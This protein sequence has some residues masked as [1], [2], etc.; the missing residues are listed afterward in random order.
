MNSY[1]YVQCGLDNV[2]LVNGFKIENTPYGAGVTI[3][4]PDALNLAIAE[5]LTEK[6]GRLSGQ[7]FRFLR[8]ELD[9]SQKR[10]GELLGREA[11]TIALWEKLPELNADAD[12]L[13]RHIYRQTKINKR[14]TYVEMVD[15][16]N[17]QDRSEHEATLNFEETEKGWKRIKAA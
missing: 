4:D 12:F 3:A 7:E 9:M 14:Q 2:W 13:I 6:P 15:V 1:H 17:N 16:L 10:I 5:Y 11:Q 8:I